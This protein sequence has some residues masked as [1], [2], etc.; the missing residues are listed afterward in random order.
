[1]WKP[2]RLS[3]T[4]TVQSFQHRVC[5]QDE[6]PRWN[7]L[8]SH[9]ASILPLL[10]SRTYNPVGAS[11]WADAGWE[12]VLTCPRA[13]CT[14]ILSSKLLFAGLVCWQQQDNKLWWC[15][16]VMQALLCCMLLLLLPRQACFPPVHVPTAATPDV[17][18]S[19]RSVQG[20]IF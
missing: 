4:A 11:L 2:V 18:L 20:L 15:Y 16:V 8:Q 9:T 17:C 14:W 1:M 7:F 3:R 10:P 12:H 13:P 5:C 19:T 6:S